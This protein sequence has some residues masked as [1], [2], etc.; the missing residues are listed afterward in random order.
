MKL[1]HNS[2]RVNKFWSDV[3]ASW[4]EIMNLYQPKCI[5]D[6][7]KSSLWYNKNICLGKKTM[8]YR[9]WVKNGVSFVNDLIDDEG[10]FL[11]LDEF[12]RKY[13]IKTNFLEYGG[14]LNCV[15]KSCKDMLNLD[16]DDNTTILQYPII[17]YNFEFLLLDNKG[18]RRLYDLLIS[19][20]L[21]VRHF[22]DK[23]HRVG[24]IRLNTKQ[25][26]NIYLIPYKCTLHTK[27]RWFQFRLTHRILGVNSFLAKIGKI[28]SNLCT[29]CRSEEETLF[30]LFCTCP[31]T[32]EDY[33]MEALNVIL[34]LCRYYIYRIKMQKSHLSLELF[35]KDVKS[36]FAQEKY[37]FTKN[38][39]L[40]KLGRKWDDYLL[41]VTA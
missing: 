11:S 14:V 10:N 35:Q 25:W 20:R 26:S 39:N 18:S 3:F 6:F 7:L 30:H 40:T 31:V 16:F 8:Y 32:A 28:E 38:G 12:R 37:I 1:L 24:D 17:P 29:F 5:S 9:H 4:T 21:V 33:R 2:Q 34:L 23:W 13:N 22:V 36:Y 15:K 19:S 27:L 41:L